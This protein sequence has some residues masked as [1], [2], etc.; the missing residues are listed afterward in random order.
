MKL[1]LL[2]AGLLGIGIL[3]M[4]V[5]ILF[6]KGGRFDKTCASVNKIINEEGEPCGFCGAQPDEQCKEDEMQDAA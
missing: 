3:G 5:K 4:A 1:F 2:I 6:I